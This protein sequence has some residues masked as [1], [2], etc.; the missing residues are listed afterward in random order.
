MYGDYIKYI[1]VRIESEKPDICI[2]EPEDPSIGFWRDGILSSTVSAL[3]EWEHRLNQT[4]KNFNLQYHLLLNKTHFDKSPNDFKWCD[5]FI[6]Y[7]K[8][9]TEKAIGKTWYKTNDSKHKYSMILIYTSQI[10]NKTMID[11][12]T[13]ELIQRAEFVNFSSSFIGKIVQHE[14]GHALG[15]HHKITTRN[16]YFDSIMKPIVGNINMITEHDVAAVEQL[17][18][19][20]FSRWYREP[21]PEPYSP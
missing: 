8:T 11:I 19:N 1:G 10:T 4:G 3:L 13:H 6:T 2:V 9:S 18:P 16:N 20:G 17:Y 15:L 21:I 12:G 7:D 5:V 14:F